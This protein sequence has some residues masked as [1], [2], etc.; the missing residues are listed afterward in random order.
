MGQGKVCVTWSR[1]GPSSNSP[2][3]GWELW[4]L[5]RVTEAFLSLL[6]KWGMP[7]ALLT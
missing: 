2:S 3:V 5:K 7:C 6:I 4:A 1:T